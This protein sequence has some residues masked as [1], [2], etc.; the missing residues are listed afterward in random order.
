MIVIVIVII[1]DCLLHF[2]S[3]KHFWNYFIIT[4]LLYLALFYSDS[5]DLIQTMFSHVELISLEYCSISICLLHI[6]CVN[7]C[8]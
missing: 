4:L 6:T 5:V 7:T 2:L 3:L 8:S 1:I